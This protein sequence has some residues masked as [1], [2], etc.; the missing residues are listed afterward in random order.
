M[1]LFSHI[2]GTRAWRDRKDRELCERTAD[3]VQE[4]VDGELPGDAGDLREHLEA[5]Q[6]C[7]GEAEAIRQLKDA[8]HRVSADADP[9][10]VSRLEE[11]GRRLCED[12]EHDT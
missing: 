10:L 5:C 12:A 11:L 6:R 8:I 9:G 2:P 4:I 1:S 3:R 7:G